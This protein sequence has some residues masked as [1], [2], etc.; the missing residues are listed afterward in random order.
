MCVLYPEELKEGKSRKGR[1]KRGRGM[2]VKERETERN[3][4]GQ[5]GKRRKAP[6]IRR[7]RRRERRGREFGKGDPRRDRGLERNRKKKKARPRTARAA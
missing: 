7:H 3:L 6:H 1:E 4:R 2:K 5:S